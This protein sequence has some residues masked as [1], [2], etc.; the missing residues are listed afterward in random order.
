MPAYYYSS[1]AGSYTLV[2][3]VADSATLLT[4]NSVAGLPSAVPYKVVLEPGQPTEEIVKVTNVAGTSLTVVRG[5]DGTAAVAHGAGVTVRHMITAEDFTLSR[6]HEDATIAHGATSALVGRND[7]VALLNKDLSSSSNTFPA[8]LATVTGTQTFTNKTLSGV[9]NTFTNIPQSAVTGLADLTQSKTV[10]TTAPVTVPNSVGTAISSWGLT[11]STVGT[12]NTSGGALSPT[13]SGVYLFTYTAKWDPKADVAGGTSSSVTRRRVYLQV[14][15][16]DI[17]DGIN[18]QLTVGGDS[19]NTEVYVTGTGTL[20]LT[21]G[22]SVQPMLFQ[23]TG[24]SGGL[25]VG[26][27]MFSLTRIA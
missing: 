21:A 23:S 2:G 24:A 9:S 22:D 16:S 7:V 13:V 15:G 20:K 4:L 14:N 19:L 18:E 26:A 8:S 27:A 17:P 6:A 5:W 3:A 12:I 25:T 1:T 10:K 11:T